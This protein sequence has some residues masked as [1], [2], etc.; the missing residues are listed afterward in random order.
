MSINFRDFRD[1]VCPVCERDI[2]GEIGHDC[3]N[4]TDEKKG[5]ENNDGD[6]DDED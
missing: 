6:R 3:T 5:G 4:D 1:M 2:S